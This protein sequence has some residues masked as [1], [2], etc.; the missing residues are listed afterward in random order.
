MGAKEVLPLTYP[1]T[2]PARFLSR[3]NRFVAQVDLA[4]QETTVHVKNTGRCRELLVPG[5][6]VWLTKSGNPKRK[7]AYDLIAVEK[8][9]R[10]INMDAQAPNAVFAQ[11]AQAGQ[12]VPGL[13]TLKAEQRFGDSRF[14]FFGTAGARSGFVEVKGVTLEE[15]GAVYFPDAPTQRGVKHLH[16]LTACLAAGYEATVCFI[17]QMSDVAFFSPNDRT[18]PAFGAALREA[19]AAGVQ[20]LALDCQVTPDS[21]TPGKPVE[22]RL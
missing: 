15:D 13:T 12:F 6:Q 2:V 16:G 19:R 22:L 14:A 5:A 9:S 1:N 4:G 11:W 21:L 10:L 18:H 20:V 8:G 17:I 7:T 3:P